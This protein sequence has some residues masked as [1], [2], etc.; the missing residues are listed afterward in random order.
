M[1]ELALIVIAEAT[2]CHYAYSVWLPFKL[3]VLLLVILTP[4]FAAV[5]Q[6]VNVCP[7]RVG[8]G[9]VPYV[10]PLVT[11]LV[12]GVTVPPLALKVTVRVV[13]V[14]VVCA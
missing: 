4:P 1:F 12:D 10:L 3:T 14:G 8:V 11:V 6:P 9:N 5:N 13:W 2:A 7:D